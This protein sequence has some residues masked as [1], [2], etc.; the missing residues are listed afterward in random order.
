MATKKHLQIEP[1]IYVCIVNDQPRVEKII[2]MQRQYMVDKMND[3]N[4]TTESVNSIM[5]I[6]GTGW[7]AGNGSFEGYFKPEFEEQIRE[8]LK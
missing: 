1:C 4:R 8:I 7:Y 6:D 2:E 3:P 5:R